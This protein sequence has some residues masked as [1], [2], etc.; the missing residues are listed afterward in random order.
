MAE[1]ASSDG[2]QYSVESPIE[3]VTRARITYLHPRGSA[4][5]QFSFVDSPTLDAAVGQVALPSS[6]Y[7]VAYIDFSHFARVRVSDGSSTETTVTKDRPVGDTFVATDWRRGV[8][9]LKTVEA[10]LERGNHLPPY[11][12]EWLA[13]YV[14]ANGTSRRDHLKGPIPIRKLE[15]HD[16]LKPR[17]KIIT[18][19]EHRQLGQEAANTR[20]TSA[21][22][23]RRIAYQL[24]LR[25]PDLAERMIERGID[26][27]KPRHRTAT[28]TDG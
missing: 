2:Q 21:E 19:A 8:H 13:R 24:S 3:T 6:L 17:L 25:R 16:D 11:L 26:C 20:E 14:G 23:A 7:E 10:V 1:H 28:P 4:E 15:V 22:M 18:Q 5:T 27:A 12:A 9:A